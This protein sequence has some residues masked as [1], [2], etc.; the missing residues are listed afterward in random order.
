MKDFW[1]C[2]KATIVKGVTGLTRE[3]RYFQRLLQADGGDGS[4][5][6]GKERGVGTARVEDKLVDVI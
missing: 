5:D 4:L 1:S 2:T 3:A 6:F